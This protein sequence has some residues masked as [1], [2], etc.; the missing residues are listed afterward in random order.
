MIYRKL[1]IKKVDKIKNKSV[2]LFRKR[3]VPTSFQFPW[4]FFLKMKLTLISESLKT[5]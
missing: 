5:H 3:T 2:D 4:K 1:C